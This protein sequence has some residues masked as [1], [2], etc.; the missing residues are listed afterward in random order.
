M[1]EGFGMVALEAME[2]A[3]PVVAAAI[4]GLGEL[5]QDG[6]TGLLVPPGEAAPLRD[7]I[8]RLARDRRLAR[9]MGEA[10]RTRALQR[11]LQTF[12]TD[13]TELLYEDALERSGR[14]AP[15]PA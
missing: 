2:R 7:A 14:G 10:G 9:R 3:R 1:G 5:V 6:E 4:G 11:F 12:C 15:S 8:V 13:R